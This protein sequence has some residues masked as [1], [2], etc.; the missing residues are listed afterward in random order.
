MY[1]AARVVSC[2]WVVSARVVTVTSTTS[3]W[4]RWAL[5]CRGENTVMRALSA[6]TEVT[7]ASSLPNLTRTGAKKLAP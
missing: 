7:W 1:A 4:A 3:S 2:A 5:G 6:E